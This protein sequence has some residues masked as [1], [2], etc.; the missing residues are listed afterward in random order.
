M[1]RGAGGPERGRGCGR[2]SR[3]LRD[4]VGSNRRFRLPYLRSWAVIAVWEG[5]SEQALDHLSEAT[6]LAAESS[7]CLK[8]S[9]RS[10]LCWEPCVR[11]G[12]SLHRRIQPGRRLRGSSG[13]WQ[14]AS[15]MRRCVRAFWP[16]HNSPRGAARP[17]RDLP[18]FQCRGEAEQALR[19]PVLHAGSS[20]FIA[21]RG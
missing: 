17:K 19:C 9:G 21:T 15:R 3:E 11:Q 4:R 6:K 12:A 10:R 16:D 1:G 18:G 5:Q 2:E 13:S 8:N 14:R 7:A 20:P